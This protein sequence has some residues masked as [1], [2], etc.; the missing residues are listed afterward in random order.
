MGILYQLYNFSVNLN[1][2]Q[3]KKIV[4]GKTIELATVHKCFGLRMP[5]HS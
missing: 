2:S 4:F 5:L 3:K 1:L